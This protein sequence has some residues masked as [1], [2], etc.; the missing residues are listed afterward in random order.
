M[1]PTIED[2]MA[3]RQRT[4]GVNKLK[5]V[6]E[7]SKKEDIIYELYLTG[8]QK[9]ER[10]K[11]VHFLDDTA[12]VVDVINLSGFCEL[13]WED[14]RNNRLREDIGLFRGIVNLDVFKNAHW[15]LILNKFDCFR[16][17]IREKKS[18]K[19]HFSDF[20]GDDENEQDVLEYVVLRLLDQIRWNEKEAKEVKKIKIPYIHFFVTSALNVQCVRNLFDYIHQNIVL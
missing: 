17:H 16:K 2:L 4:T 12:V 8:G 19:E 9:N 7:Q 15:I 18:M 14:N 3:S 5:F 1:G 6:M 11:W 20:I 13:L 10:R